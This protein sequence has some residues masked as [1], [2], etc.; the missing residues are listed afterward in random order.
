M[1]LIGY[2]RIILSHML[3][4]CVRG[5]WFKGQPRLSSSMTEY[6]CLISSGREVAENWDNLNATRAAFERNR[7]TLLEGAPATETGPAVEKMSDVCILA[8]EQRARARV[9]ASFLVLASSGFLVLI[10]KQPISLPKQLL[11]RCC[12]A[13]VVVF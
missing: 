11:L 2:K 12:S 1:S 7:W 6:A 5:F 9:V 4:T 13:I 3:G 10:Q 8:H